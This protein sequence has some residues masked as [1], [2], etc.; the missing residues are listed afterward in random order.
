MKETDKAWVAAMIDSRAHIVKKKNRDRAEGSE[1]ICLTLQTKHH[2]IAQ[3]LCAMTG[4]A[5]ALLEQKKV[6]PEL[7][8]R[9]CIEHC[10][11]AHVH[12]DS[13]SALPMIT[14]WTVTGTA[15][16]VVLYNVRKYMVTSREPWDWAMEQSMRQMKV[17]GPGSG[18]TKQVATRLSA[19]GWDL[20]PL[21]RRLLPKELEVAK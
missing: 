3:R 6:S 4:T 17:Q 2:E 8:R 11:Q 18:S 12:V 14:T 19:L 5:P 21:M 7:M 20:P 1:Q 13:L 15:A 10:P 9:G 16:A